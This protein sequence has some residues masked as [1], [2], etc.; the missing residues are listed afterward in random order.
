MAS[1]LE[2]LML[3]TQLQTKLQVTQREPHHLQKTE[4]LRPPSLTPSI[5]WLLLE[6]LFIKIMLQNSWWR[7]KTH[8]EES[9]LFLARPNLSLSSENKKA[10]RWTD[11]IGSYSTHIS[12]IAHKFYLMQCSLY[13]VGFLAKHW[14]VTL[15][16]GIFL[17]ASWISSWN[18]A[19]P[20]LLLICGII[21]W[22]GSLGKCVFSKSTN[23]NI[24]LWSQWMAVGRIE[25]QCYAL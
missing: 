1:D 10:T 11:S 17:I 18:V 15:T 23:Q 3:C 5:P 16:G 2:L 7:P 4:L 24:P 8:Q 25:L 9:W 14:T 19:R 21:F 20:A 6:I 12:I 13:H 22:L